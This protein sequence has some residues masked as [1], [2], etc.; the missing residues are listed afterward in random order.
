MDLHH[1]LLA[2][3]PAHSGLPPTTDVFCED[4]CADQGEQADKNY[5]V[6]AQLIATNTKLGRKLVYKTLLKGK[7]SRSEPP[8]IGQCNEMATGNFVDFLF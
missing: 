5:F 2:G 8:S 6:D 4:A 3:L 1:L 7:E